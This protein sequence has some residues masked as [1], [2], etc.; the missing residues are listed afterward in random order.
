MYDTECE[1]SLLF[2]CRYRPVSKSVECKQLRQY[3][4]YTT[5]NRMY[6]SYFYMP[7]TSLKV[8]WEVFFSMYIFIFLFVPINF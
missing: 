1:H 6:I 7:K 2:V 3:I 5:L 4:T 8:H